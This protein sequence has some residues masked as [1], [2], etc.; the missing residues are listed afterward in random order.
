MLSL[1]QQIKKLSELKEC[2]PFLSIWE[3]NFIDD[4]L[5]LGGSGI[6]VTAKQRACIQNLLGKYPNIE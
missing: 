1:K 6:F 3:L 5:S 4:I 2:T